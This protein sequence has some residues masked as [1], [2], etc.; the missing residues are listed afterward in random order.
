MELFRNCTSWPRTSGGPGSPTSA[1]SSASSTRR[2]GASSTTTRWP[3]LQRLPSEEI[4]RRVADLE[5]QT[6]INQAHRRLQHLSP[7]RR[8]LGPGPRRPPPR[9]AGRLLLGRVRPPPVAPHLLRR[10]RGAGRRPPEEHERPGHAGRRR[11]AALPRR[12]RPPVDRRERLA[13]GAS[14]SR[15]PPPSCRSSRCSPPAASRS[16]SASSSPAATSSCASGGSSVGR[17]H[18]LLLDAR[19]D[20]N[21]PADQALTA[22]LYGGDQETRI[23]QEI[24]LGVGGHRALRRAWGSSPS[25][26]HLNEGH[27]AFALLERAR[28]LVERQG[29]TAAEA[30]RE[31]AGDDAASP[32]TRRSR[33]ATTASAPTSPPPTWR[34]SPAASGCRSRR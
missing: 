20:A 3:C 6:R 22:R 2:P 27:S 10:P 30:L 7:R 9:P 14:T 17:S 31:V 32:P 28:E 18:L 33:P 26:L 25:V 24:L 13:A 4:A 19:D 8:E 5:M 21:S 34:R 23:Q 16:A 11:R 12:L 15:S 1:P 29:I